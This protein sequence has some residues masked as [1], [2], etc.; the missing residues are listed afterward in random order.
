MFQNPRSGFTL[1]FGFRPTCIFHIT[2]IHSRIRFTICVSF[3]KC[4]RIRVCLFVKK[5]HSSRRFERI[6]S[7]RPAAVLAGACTYTVC[8]FTRKSPNFYLLYTSSPLRNTL[9][10]IYFHASIP[11]EKRYK[12]T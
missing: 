7:V 4:D 6:K 12:C 11:I 2:Y 8:N 3:V 1:N 5:K 10:K 9:L